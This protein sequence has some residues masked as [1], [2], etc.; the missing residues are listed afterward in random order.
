LIALDTNILVYAES[1]DNQHGR[2]EKAHHII[3]SVSAIETC[4]PFQVIGEYLNV[5]RR[6]RI[7]DMNIAVERASN[8]TDL[9]QTH[10]TSFADLEQ[11]VDLSQAFNLQYF[12]ALIIAVALR[13]GATILLSEDMQDG[14][15]IDGLRVVNPFVAENDAVLADYF[16]KIMP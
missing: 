2:Y 7:V 12:D 6:K 15:E 4:L 3:A 13:A 1:P 16:A 5:C 8:Y 9:F 14:L 10:P 11:A